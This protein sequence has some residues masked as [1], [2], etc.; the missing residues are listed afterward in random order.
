[1]ADKR[2]AGA[3]LREAGADEAARREAARLLGRSTSERKRAAVAANGRK[4]PPGPGR[5]FRPL[6]SFPCTCGAGAA[7]EGHKTTCPRGLAIRRRRK[8]GLL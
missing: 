4:A 5:P 1:M 6:E 2:D 8:A 7:I 3:T